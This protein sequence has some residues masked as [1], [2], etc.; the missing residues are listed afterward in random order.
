MTKHPIMCYNFYQRAM[1]NDLENLLVSRSRPNVSDDLINHWNAVHR[2][3]DE[4]VIDMPNHNGR[5]MF[6]SDK[7]Q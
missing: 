3:L 5:N 6:G 1:C 4:L 7:I 2:V